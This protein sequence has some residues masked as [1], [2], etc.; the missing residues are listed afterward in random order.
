MLAGVVPP[1]SLGDL[2]VCDRCNC[3]GTRK[4][5]VPN[6][7][8]RNAPLLFAGQAPGV[9]EDREGICPFTGE[10]GQ[11][12][13]DT[14]T[15]FNIERK[16]ASFINLIQCF[17]GR[18][19]MGSDNKP[20]K[21][22]ISA[23]DVWIEK[24]I[25]IASPKVIVTL[26]DVAT[27]AIA[28]KTGIT[29]LNG[30]PV[31]NPKYPGVIIVPVIHPAYV[32]RN[33]E[34]ETEFVFG[35]S[36][37]VKYSTGQVIDTVKD[38][39]YVVCN[40]KELIDECFKE[41]ESASR[42]AVDIETSSLNFTSGYIIS[43]AFSSK[44]KT[45]WCIPI[46][47]ADPAMFEAIKKIRES[48]KKITAI[49]DPVAFCRGMGIPEPKCVINDLYPEFKDRLN[50]LM[51]ESKVVKIFHNYKF[52]KIFLRKFGVNVGQFVFDTYVAHH[53]L[54]E[55]SY[56]HGLKDLAF[57]HTDMGDYDKKIHEYLKTK[58]DS[59]AIVPSDEIYW[60]NCAD[61]DATLRLFHRFNPDIKEQ[62]LELL[63][64][65]LLMPA[66]DL[67]SEIEEHG[68]LIDKEYRKELEG[69]LTKEAEL[70]DKKLRKMTNPDINFGSPK[71]LKKLLFEDLKLPSI[72]KTDKGNDS[73]DSEVLEELSSRHPIPK[74]I[75][76]LR[77]VQKLN[78]T[79][80]KD[81][82][83]YIWVDGMIHAN[84]N[85][86]GTE[87]GRIVVRDPPLQTIPKDPIELL[88]YLSYSIGKDEY[89]D[90]ER[91]PRKN[92]HIK[93]LIISPPGYKVVEMDYSQAELRVLAELSK[94]AELCLC[95][96]QGIDIHLKT[97]IEV[98]GMPEDA[99]KEVKAAFRKPAKIINF[100]IAY[101]MG[102][103][104][105]AKDAGISIEK[106][107][108]Y[109]IKWKERYEGVD[110]WQNETIEF[111]R[112]NGYVTSLYGRRR[113]LENAL[114]DPDDGIRLHAEREAIN[115]PVQATA[116]EMTLWAGVK[117][118]KTLS[119]KYDFFPV[120]LIHDANLWYVRTE[121]VTDFC[122]DSREIANHPPRFTIPILSDFKV[123][124]TNNW[125]EMEEVKL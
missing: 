78:S 65:G 98:L 102:Q 109:L 7:I 28:G 6:S 64:S 18:S 25:T 89:L 36:Q 125:G 5:V 117:I 31:S 21:E 80:V 116:N 50:K 27:K 101:G 57:K 99:S 44:E 12:L 23:C 10:A 84:F 69:A 63:M 93:K 47:V 1:H 120:N 111:A 48:E 72:K 110:R 108:A 51:G 104:L 29:S 87:T 39:K 68:I 76:E 75:I 16:D 73:T 106:A 14:L 113:R 11:L 49:P 66:S 38:N 121:H 46:T 61:V 79:Y 42:F 105:L 67:I 115:A 9:T 40:T 2:K 37:A 97:S 88:D 19:V 118:R 22:Q 85:I 43:I 52:D 95:F 96:L 20:T 32:K 114:C 71:Q 77:S 86:V 41:L 15:R 82:E 112:K 123:S 3:V 94:D 62:G 74:L 58:D 56:G 4:N 92:Y 53:L 8:I 90:L 30:K 122:R 81:I 45:G 70:I 83:S 60:Y 26:G 119:S 124:V 107:K 24:D 103:K 55:N 33:P 91:L 35:I 54:N 100:G 13:M 17:P 34:K 59:Y